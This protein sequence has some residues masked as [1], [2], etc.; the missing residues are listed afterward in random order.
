MKTA[1]NV[2]LAFIAGM[3]LMGFLNETESRN[4]ELR[5][6]MLE[7]KLHIRSLQDSNSREKCLRNVLYDV[8][9]QFIDTRKYIRQHP[10]FVQFEYLCDY[11]IEDLSIV[12]E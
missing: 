8:A 9:G 7:A 10:H 12:Y 6:K 1:I 5:N 11:D 4:L 2:I 3:T